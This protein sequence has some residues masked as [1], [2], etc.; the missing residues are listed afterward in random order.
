MNDFQAESVYGTEVVNIGAALSAILTSW[1]TLLIAL[2]AGAIGFG[3]YAFSLPNQYRAIVVLSPVKAESGIGGGL[4]SQFGGLAAIAGID[5]GGTGSNRATESIA[6]LGSSGF[7]RT[8]IEQEN[9]LP[10]LYGEK[11]DAAAKKWKSDTAAP[12]LEIAVE[13]FRKKICKLAED[14]KTGLV[15]L[16]V[17]WTDPVVAA[18]WANQLVA[19]VNERLRDEA[20]VDSRQRIEFLEKELSKTTVVDTQRAIFGLIEGQLNNAMVANVQREYAFKVIDRAVAPDPKRKIGPKRTFITFGG[21][22]A[23]MTAGVLFVLWRKRS[24]WLIRPT[25][26]APMP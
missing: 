7:A 21:G 9:L 17:D 11:W 19:K 14:R 13:Y 5:L 8:F 12:S 25:P 6:T 2:F 16:N 20:I 18:R 4:R 24:A 1:K 23:A 26:I 15:T 3:W 22:F 10:V